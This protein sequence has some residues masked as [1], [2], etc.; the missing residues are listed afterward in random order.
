MI[1]RIASELDHGNSSFDDSSDVEIW[2]VAVRQARYLDRGKVW[3][4]VV[5]HPA[6]QRAMSYSVWD[7]LLS[8]II[9]AA[10][11]TPFRGRGGYS[12]LPKERQVSATPLDKAEAEALDVERFFKFFTTSDV[13]SEIVGKS[14]LDFGSGYGGRTLEYVRTCGAGRACGVEPF[15][16]CIDAGRA[17]TAKHSL[18][19]RVEFRLCTQDKIPYSDEEFD[20]I[21]SFDVLEHVADPRVSMRELMRVI[22]PGGTMYAVFPIYRGAFSHHLDYLTMVPGLHL[23]F[24]PERVLRVTNEHLDRRSDIV[25]SR[26]ADPGKHY[27]TGQPILPTLNGMCLQDFKD[28]AQGWIVR[29]FELNGIADIAFGSTSIIARIA[30]PLTKLPPYLSEPMVFN[31]AAILERP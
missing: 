15:Q 22:K 2:D 23:L 4:V 17:L 10:Q 29:S 20:A 12:N 13:R 26:H 16:I 7:S 3:V 24:S 19:D 11:K 1:C 25:V 6:W 18:S 9:S 8:S 5:P 28:A 21:I 27:I 14:I 30:K 31:V